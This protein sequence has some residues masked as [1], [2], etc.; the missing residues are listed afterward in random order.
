MRGGERGEKAADEKQTVC[1]HL[2]PQNTYECLQTAVEFLE[3]ISK[4]GVCVVCGEGEAALL[5]KPV[6]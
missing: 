1:D 2:Y 4:V 6:C 5:R 3:I